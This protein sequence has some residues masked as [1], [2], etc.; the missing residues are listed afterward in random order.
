MSTLQPGE[1]FAGYTVERLLGAGG[2]GEVYVA[3]HPRLPR[4]DALK[5]LAAQLAHDDQFRRRFERE[6]DVVAGF[7]HPN[8]VKV[9]DRGEADGRLWIALELVDGT[10]LTGVIA[11]GP[12]PAAETIAIVAEIADA[13]DEAADHGLVHRDVKPANILLDKRGRALL[14]DFGIAH[15]AAEAAEL[16]GTGMTI[17]TVT[18][19]SPEQLQSLPL[20]ARADQYSLAC[21]A[22]TLLTGVPPFGG[23]NAVSIIMAHLQQPVPAVTSRRGDLSPAVDAVFARALAKNPAERFPTSRAF[24]EA[25]AAALDVTVAAPAHGGSPV[26]EPRRDVSPPTVAATP[27]TVP[28]APHQVPPGQH[29]PFVPAGGGYPPFAPASGAGPQIPGREPRKHRTALI[30]GAVVGVLILVGAV[31]AVATTV[32]GHGHGGGGGASSPVTVAADAKKLK[33]DPVT[34][35][36]ASLATEPK[37]ALWIYKP[38]ANDYSSPQAIGGTETTVYMAESDADRTT[39]DLVDAAT[40]KLQRTVRVTG[41]DDLYGCRNLATANKIICSTGSSS[42]G[43]AIVDLTTGAATTLPTGSG[44]RLTVTGDTALISSDYSVAAYGL[45]G[46]KLWSAD[47]STS[48]TDTVPDGSPVAAVT[49]GAVFTLRDI[50]TGKVLF[51]HDASKAINPEQDVQTTWMPFRGGFAV[52]NDADRV[53]LYN[54]AGTKTATVD[55]GWLPVDYEP[56]AAATGLP[57]LTDDKS[58]QTA[59]FDPATGRPAVTVR[60]ESDASRILAAVGT[61]VAVSYTSP[62]AS[63][64]SGSGYATAWFDAYSGGGGQDIT[65]T[66]PKV[67]GTDGE[68]LLV[69]N[70]SGSSGSFGAYGPGRG[71]AADW[72]VYLKNSYG[73][74]VAGGKL[75]DRNRR[76]L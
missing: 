63:A 7:S 43:Y 14:T 11:R 53:D 64:S 22:H 48:S 57:V 31:I 3:R 52:V 69:S 4:N 5:V 23:G 17:G 71:Y 76:L 47:D 1:V 26:T 70:D 46:R 67:L 41:F 50:T 49:D 19:A 2:M 32:G 16:T 13:L 54:A 27:H 38:S 33:R 62:T 28:A 34:P 35:D 8:I 10:D 68:R 21:T 59:T 75:Y 55:D 66:L 36:M 45:T 58:N 39:I 25:L 15:L 51:T 73:L 44:T 20:D 61:A 65:V 24:A 37:E 60:L 74:L 29:P 9:H 6:A 42:G 12:V 72:T 56:S 40:G 18:Y 30:V